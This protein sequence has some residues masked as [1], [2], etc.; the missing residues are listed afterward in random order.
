MFTELV[1]WLS[2]EKVIHSLILIWKPR[3]TQQQ[4]DIIYH[5]YKTNLHLTFVLLN[6]TFLQR[7]INQN[8][9]RKKITYHNYICSAHNH[10]GV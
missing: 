8:I 4:N 7:L 5:D 6:V 9:T 3:S 10:T 1:Y 2:H